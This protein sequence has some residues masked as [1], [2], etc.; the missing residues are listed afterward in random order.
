MLQ[1]IEYVGTSKEVI[2]ILLTAIHEKSK[3]L[4]K[5]E[6]LD[7]CFLTF[8]FLSTPFGQV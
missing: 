1:S 6:N 3:I 5:I 7:Q 8:F 2:A 4:L